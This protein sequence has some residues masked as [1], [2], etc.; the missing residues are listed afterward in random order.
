M[1][2]HDVYDYHLR[3]FRKQIWLLV[4]VSKLSNESVTQALG[5][6]VE[7]IVQILQTAPRLLYMRVYSSFFDHKSFGLN[8]VNLF[9]ES[10]YFLQCRNN[11]E[12]IIRACFVEVRK[13]SQVGNGTF[14]YMHGN[15]Y[16][17]LYIDF[18]SCIRCFKNIDPCICLVKHGIMRHMLQ[19]NERYGSTER[20]LLASGNGE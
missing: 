8:P 18:V 15:K 10:R 12:R 5:T 7:G 3:Y 13:Y 9:R 1:K 14:F 19:R 16:L 17:I 11:I 2:A 20:N 4:K 6:A